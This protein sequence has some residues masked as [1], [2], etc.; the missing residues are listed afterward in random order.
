[1]KMRLFQ[2]G[3]SDRKAPVTQRKTFKEQICHKIDSVEA[4]GGAIRELIL[5]VLA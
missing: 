3:T 4:F 5:D 1:M 2:A